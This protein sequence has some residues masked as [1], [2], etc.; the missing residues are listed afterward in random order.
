MMTFS[1]RHT[2]L[3]TFVKGTPCAPLRN[4]IFPTPFLTYKE[5]GTK[6]VLAG[7]EKVAERDAYART[8][9]TLHRLDPTQLRTEIY[10]LLAATV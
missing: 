3:R 7:R 1:A 9:G 5:R 8:H 4:A 2:T 10:Y 6:I